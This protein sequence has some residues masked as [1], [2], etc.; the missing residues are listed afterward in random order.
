MDWS[1]DFKL[2]NVYVAVQTCDFDNSDICA[3]LHYMNKTTN[4]RSSQNQSSQSRSYS[5]LNDSSRV[6]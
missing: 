3:N 4:V 1:N 5:I 2:I 6:S